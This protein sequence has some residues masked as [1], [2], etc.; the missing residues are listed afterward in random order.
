YVEAENVI[1]CANLVICNKPLTETDARNNATTYSW[2]TATGQLTKVVKPAGA[3][4]DLAYDSYTGTDG[5]TL[6]L[7]GRKTEKVSAGQN[8]VTTYA[9]GAANKYV[10]KSA[11][12]DPDGAASS[13]TC[14]QFD[15]IGN[16][17]GTTDPRAAAACP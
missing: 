17:I 6:R 16:L 15:A 9:Y 11:T 1:T 2:D 8:I 13:T 4:T 14:F 3:Q 7:L 12:V 10:L 5:G